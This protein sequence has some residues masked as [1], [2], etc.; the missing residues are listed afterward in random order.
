MFYTA[1]FLQTLMVQGSKGPAWTRSEGSSS[2]R[3][4]R[5]RRRAGRKVEEEQ[6]QKK[7]VEKVRIRGRPPDQGTV[8]L[9]T[10]NPKAARS[11]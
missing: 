1:R 3:S 2:E 10:K 11:P 8:L 4:R 5:V 7:K 6:L 9:H